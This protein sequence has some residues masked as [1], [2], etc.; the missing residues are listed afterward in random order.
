MSRSPQLRK[1]LLATVRADCEN[2]PGTYRMIADNDRVIYVGKSRRVRTRLL[3]YFR[4]KG[5][6][7]KAARILRHA[8]RIEW[9]YAPNEFSALLNELRLIKRYRPHFNRAMVTDEW[10]RAYIA[11]T[12]DPVPALRIVRRTDD[13]DAA[14]IWG[15]FR[16]V[17]ALQEAVQV[18]AELSGV[19][20]CAIDP[21]ARGTLARPLWFTDTPTPPTASRHRAPACFRGQLG[22][23][24]AP[25]IGQGSRTDYEDAV[26]RAGRFL[27]SGDDTL[28]NAAT[29]RM[30]EAATALHFERA[31]IWRDKAS[32][33]AWLRT[34]LTHFQASM[35]RLSF[36][37]NVPA[38][39]GQD[40]SN[41][42]V[43]VIRRGTVRAEFP[44][45]L[46]REDN[47]R[48][49]EAARALLHA[50]E[51]AEID[52]PNH[53]LD[54]FYLVASWFR[55]HPEERRHTERY[56]QTPGSGSR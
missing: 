1:Q 45:P 5:R 29:Q 52:I 33:L 17:T 24:S 20:D 16:K 6:R 32:R 39:D 22:S 28:L 42:R 51:S 13:T 26:R 36:R 44:W 11:L 49:D 7:N 10:P 12:A 55:R 43:Y 35:D 14:M 8:V 21:Q 37:Y 18:L 25:C 41:G 54:E 47:A 50:Q 9:E 15:P 27:D 38:L 2:R 53:D 30:E 34:R 48:I 3:S 19:R 40:P 56:R 23:C 46:S 31:A 4:A